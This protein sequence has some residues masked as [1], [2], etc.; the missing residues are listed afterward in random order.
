M[1]PTPIAAWLASRIG[2]VGERFTRADLDAYQLDRLRETLRHAR[3]RSAFYGRHLAGIG[4]RLTTLDGLA[5]L[6]FTTATDLRQCGPEF[7]CVSQDT[8]ERVVTL[9]TSGT[10]GAPKR[11][12]FT[13][14]DQESTIDFFRAGMSTFTSPGD[15]VI[16][17]LPGERPGSVGDLLATALERLGAQPVRHGLVRTLAATLAVMHREQVT[18]AV[19]I[20]TQ[21]LALAR[22]DDGLELDSVL[23]TTDHVPVA[24]TR[25]VERAWGC[26]V[27]GHYGM[28]EMGLGGAVE[29]LARHGYHLR[30]ADLYFEVVGSEDG[31]PVPD[32]VAGE[33]VF[34]TL[35][36]RGAPLIR[37]RTGDISQFVPEACPCGAPLRTLERVAGRL[38]GRVPIGADQHVTMA[39][40]DEALFPIGSVLDFSA[41]VSR[42]SAAATRSS[43]VC[44]RLDMRVV[45][46]SE[47][48]VAG[49]VDAA[50]ESLPAIRHARA[51]GR[52]RTSIG[53]Q[54]TRSVVVRPGKRT[55][56]EV[57]HHA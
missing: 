22:H 56:V 57:E 14:A 13:R 29:C 15:K 8:I 10:T 55:I 2:V 21:V 28:T 17:L 33:V 52:L 34:T 37:Y 38:D 19:G 54:R 11:L 23:L 48:R 18:G 5:R 35:T 20:P 7:L 9:N 43:A 44:L 6:P 51:S 24:V 41:V 32:G 3:T 27:Y 1:R 31:T 50:L 49:A 47:D 45:E 36:R 42:P 53:V 26:R 39:E 46:D 40:L 4:H 12:Y 16:I 30:E 25:A